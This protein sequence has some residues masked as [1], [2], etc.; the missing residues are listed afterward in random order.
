MS[1]SIEFIFRQFIADA[2]VIGCEQIT[3]GHINA[4]WKVTTKGHEA[5]TWML[6]GINH[7][8]FKNIS[9]LMKNIDLVTR[10]LAQNAGEGKSDQNRL[11]LFRTIDGALYFE[12]QAGKPW[13]L[14]NFIENSRVY[15][16]VGDSSLAYEGGSA[17]GRFVRSLEGLDPSALCSTIP[18]FHDFYLRRD[19]YVEALA[20]AETAR[21]TKAAEEIR[22]AES[23]FPFMDRF[24]SKIAEGAFPVRITH[25]DTKF[26]NILFSPDGKAICIIDLDTV[27]PGTILFDFGD[28]IRTATNTAAEDEPDLSK[29]G[30]DLRLF[31]A[32]TRGY[33]QECAGVLSHEEIM[34]LPEATRY[35]TLLIGI[36]FLTDFLAGDVYYNTSREGQNLDR[37]RVQFAMDR[38]LE[39]NTAEMR[40][41]AAKF[42]TTKE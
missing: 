14:F 35:M 23:R 25:N 38:C 5:N 11:Q 32:Y 21:K 31:S 7:R 17:F 10:H 19:Q 36:R 2:E 42:A 33:L 37:A 9:G 3:H 40:N 20:G 27:M 41:I 6:Q 4:S 13:R 16:I 15:D 34:H 29:V 28:A 1:E 39:Q 12:D 30:F 22:Y 8:I 18:R 26:N 24:F